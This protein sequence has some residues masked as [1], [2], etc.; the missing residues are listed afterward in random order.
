[1]KPVEFK[2]VPY[3]AK[4]VICPKDDCMLPAAESHLD[5]TGLVHEMINICPMGHHW[6]VQL[7][8]GSR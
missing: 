4:D 8:E 2:Q 1:M 5:D 6:R 3:F 7:L